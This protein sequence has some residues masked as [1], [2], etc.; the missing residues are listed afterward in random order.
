M[1]RIPRT[2]NYAPGPSTTPL[3]YSAARR[4]ELMNDTYIDGGLA[5]I[6]IDMTGGFKLPRSDIFLL[7]WATHTISGYQLCQIMIKVVAFN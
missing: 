5:F 6:E 4:T 1:D 3:T 7:C 2:G